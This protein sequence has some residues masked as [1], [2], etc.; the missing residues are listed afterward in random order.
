M[1]TTSGGQMLFRTK[2]WHFVSLVLLA[3][4]FYQPNS[5]AQTGPQPPCGNEPIPSYPNL[6]DPAVVKA[7]HKSELGDYWKPPA[8]TEWGSA[9]FTTLVT[10]AARFRYS[11]NAKD[12]LRRIGAVSQ[13][14]GLRYWSTT[15]KQWRALILEAHAM[16]GDQ[17]GRRRQDFNP[18]E[19]IEGRVFYFEQEDNLSGKG[20]YRMRI[21]AASANRLVIEIEN[22]STVHYLLVPLFRPGEVQSMYFL[23]RE[24]PEVWRFYSIVRTRTT[25]SRLLTGNESSAI[26]RAVALYRYFVG[27]PMDQEPPAAR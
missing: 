5:H 26:N 14:A 11:L 18:D 6:S 15:H 12:L 17:P 25:S 22:V 1:K 13:L 2:S 3:S 10:I 9:D 23:D 19:M 4:L 27:I 20:T 24:S 16:T 8:C 21:A 7:W